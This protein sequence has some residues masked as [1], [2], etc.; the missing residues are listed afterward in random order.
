MKKLSFTGVLLALCL[1]LPSASAQTSQ[2]D[3]ALQAYETGH[4][5]QA[6]V[7]AHLAGQAGNARAMELAATMLWHGTRLYGDD[8]P[9]DR[10]EA[11]RLF[12]AAVALDRDGQLNA[13]PY[14]LALL[15]RAPARAAATQLD[16]T[17]SATPSPTM[18]ATPAADASVPAS[19]RTTVGVQT[20]QGAAVQRK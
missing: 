17:A 12:R 19:K 8:V 1:W 11:I 5:R 7:L 10:A 4:Y 2:L 15:A 3:D 18:S 16:A 6:L 13:A 9:G 14:Y 20:G